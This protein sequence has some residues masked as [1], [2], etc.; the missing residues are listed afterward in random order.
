MIRT[1]LLAAAFCAPAIAHAQEEAPRRTRVTI[2]PQVQ[3]RFPGADSYS[4]RPYFDLARTRGD[5]PYRFEAPDESTSIALISTDT[6]TIGPALGFEG[7]RRS[8]DAGGLDRV[9]FTVELGGFARWT[10]AEQFRLS[11]EARHGVNGHGATI[12]MVGA[13]YIARDGNRWLF[14]V[15]PR[16]TVGSGKYHRTYFGV[17]AREA[18]ATGV[19]AY[20]P[21]GAFLMA[22]ATGSASRQLSARWGVFG[23][24]K[25]DRLLGDA[26][27]SPV[28]DRFG[29]RSQWSGGVG[30]SYTFG[31]GL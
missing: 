19:P 14:S 22:G 28:V 24:A 27:D 6:L 23:F 13:D 1:V 2:G 3:P 17:N 4:V 8:R 26:A 9:G 12:G 7:R 5:D 20:R 15:G 11:V 30:L 29:S 18:A 10:V 16:L 21:D 31:R 25:Y